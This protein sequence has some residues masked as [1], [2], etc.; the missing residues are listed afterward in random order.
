MLKDKKIDRRIA[1]RTN[2]LDKPVLR[3]L[4][5][6]LSRVRH[7]D[8]AKKEQRITNLTVADYLVLLL[9]T[10]LRRDEAAALEWDRVNLK[11]KLFVIENTKNGQTHVVPMSGPV[12]KML[13]ARSHAPDRH[14][15]WVF[16]A[17][18]GQGPLQEPRYQI[19]KIGEIIG[20]QF[21]SHDLRRTFA[22][23]AESYGLDNYAIKRALNHK[24]Q[25]ITETYIQGRA[26][27]MRQWFDAIADE[28]YW[29]TYEEPPD[30]VY[31]DPPTD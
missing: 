11:D 21:T 6:E 25:D 2:Y 16:P 26:E 30:L 19:Y 17:R 8:Y 10:G 23:L 1:P 29:W 3:E 12:E 18:G 4:V 20:H 28:I 22:P 13:I 31:P 27:K 5:E 24:T 15:R 9:F 14:E 7:P